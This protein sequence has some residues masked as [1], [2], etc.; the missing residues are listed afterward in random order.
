M[1]SF[2]TNYTLRGPSQQAVAAVLLGRSAFVTPTQGGCVVV[3]DEQSDDQDSSVITE[4]GSKLSRELQCP[5]LAVL[6]HDDDILW[7][8]LHLGGELT[9]EYDSSP[10]YFDA[11]AEPCAPVGGDAQEL[12]RAFG[13]IAIAE[14]EAILRT[15]SFD[16]DGYTYAY[17]RHAD[18]V[19]AVGIPPFAV[20]AGFRYISDGELPEG[21]A[22]VDLVRV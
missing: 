15:S 20:G 7:Y 8:Q 18:L 4:L 22:D 6:N 19:R 14:V 9:D 1:G 3:F 2:Y 10:G 13:S 12:C 5:V 21:L 17:E 11:A 16:D